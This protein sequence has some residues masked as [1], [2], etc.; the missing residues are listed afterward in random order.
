MDDALDFRAALVRAREAVETHVTRVDAMGHAW[1]ETTLTDLLLEQAWPA[2]RALPFNQVQEGAVGADWLW[3]WLDQ[4]GT[5][6][7][8]LVQAKRLHADPW[9]I[10]YGYRGGAQLRDLLS[11]A[12]ALSVPPVYCLYLGSK[13]FRAQF[14]CD[15]HE[16]GDCARCHAATVSLQPGII[17]AHAAALPVDF[18]I[19][20]AIPL[21]YLG[22]PNQDTRPPLLA[23]MSLPADLEQFLY[24]DQRGANAVARHLLKRVIE[25]RAGQ[26]SVDVGDVRVAPDQVYKD[27]PDDRGHLYEPYFPNILRGLRTS[28]PDYLHDLLAGRPVTATLPSSVAG[29]VVLTL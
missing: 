26:L 11:A 13:A 7:G 22:D 17:A 25:V 9:R 20:Q 23:G 28:P 24:E 6:F 12:E 27:L 10:D 18:S 16:E 19:R 14:A 15:A 29:V 5:A 8:M 1:H 2:M 4:D 3:W 21:E